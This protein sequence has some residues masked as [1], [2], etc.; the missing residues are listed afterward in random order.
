MRHEQTSGDQASNQRLNNLQTFINSFGATAKEDGRHLLLLP[1]MV[2]GGPYVESAER[3][4]R[5][6]QAVLTALGAERFVPKE[7]EHIGYFELPIDG[8][9]S[10]RPGRDAV[11]DGAYQPDV[12]RGGLG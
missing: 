2:T 10:Q 5:A 8:E 11:T 3:R 7:G 6:R 1:V 4:L 9:A 12:R